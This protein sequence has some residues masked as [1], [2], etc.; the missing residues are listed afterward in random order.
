[1]VLEPH[2]DPYDVLVLQLQGQKHWH[3][4]TPR[5]RVT[6]SAASQQ[7]VVIDDAASRGSIEWHTMSPAQR[8]MLRELQLDKVE[9]CTIY[10]VSDT[11][12]SMDCHEFD[13]HT[14]DV[15]YMPKVRCLDWSK[16]L[17]GSP[18]CVSAER[19]LRVIFFSF[20]LWP[21]MP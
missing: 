1:M 3:T 21:C 6:S 8:C 9:G 11:D 15:L 16:W 14:G 13:M 4:C 2:T 12:S 19:H 7:S 20:F 18:A 5:Q 17:K 10:T